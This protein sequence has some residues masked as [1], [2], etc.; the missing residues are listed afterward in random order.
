MAI[1]DSEAG[2][3]DVPRTVAG[4]GAI[5]GLA[6]GAGDVVGISGSSIQSCCR[7]ENRW[8]RS[9][10]PRSSSPN[11]RRQNTM[12]AAMQAL[13]LVAEYNGPTMFARI[14]VMRALNRHV[15]RAFD[16]SRKE[17]HWGRRKLARER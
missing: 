1:W 11:C 7:A 3:A 10:T 13:L 8:S 12:P 5:R 9:A 16:P 17:K 2:R 6:F 14:G 4:L 15:Q